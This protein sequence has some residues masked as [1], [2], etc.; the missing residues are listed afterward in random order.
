VVRS[1]G[2]PKQNDTLQLAQV[3]H[4]QNDAD[5]TGMIC[6]ALLLLVYQ[7]MSALWAM[8]GLTLPPNQLITNH[9][10]LQICELFPQVSKFCLSEWLEIWDCC[11]GNKLHSIYPRVGSVEHSKN[12]SCYYSVLINRLHIGHS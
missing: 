9:C 4:H 1:H 3:Y 11:E 12:M 8:K 6:A 7:A 2:G 10:P 5:Q